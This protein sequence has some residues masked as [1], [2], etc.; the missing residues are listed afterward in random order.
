MCVR[1]KDPKETTRTMAFE[2]SMKDPN[3]IVTFFKT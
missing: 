1:E 3:P 2:L